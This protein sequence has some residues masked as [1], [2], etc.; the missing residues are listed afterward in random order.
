[1]Q[2]GQEIDLYEV[3]S[4]H[5]PR[6]FLKSLAIGGMVWFGLAMFSGSIL[7]GFLIG[8]VCV[9][10]ALFHTWRRFLEP[11]SFSLFCIA[12]VFWCDPQVLQRM[13]AAWRNI[14]PG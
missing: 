1:M 14:S 2:E 11:L 13:A 8:L 7:K 6:T 3:L 12:V 4:G 9:F 5:S 10:L